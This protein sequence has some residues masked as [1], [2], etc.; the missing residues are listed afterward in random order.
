VADA[1]YAIFD[2]MQGGIKFFHGWKN[3]LGG[4]KTFQVKRLYRDPELITWGKPCIWVSNKDPRD[5][6]EIND[7]EWLEGNCIFYEVTSSFFVPVT[8]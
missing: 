4:Q 6:M 7:R 5:D 3:W 8:N 2:D 1:E